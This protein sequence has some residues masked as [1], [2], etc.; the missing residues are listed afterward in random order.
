M[1]DKITVTCPKH[2]DFTQLAYDHLNGH[3]CPKCGLIESRNETEIYDYICSII[4]KE[5]VEQSNRK[6]LN[7]YEI[8]IYIPQIKVGIEYNGL[9]WHSVKYREDKNYH[10]N[11]TLKANEKGVKLIQIF[12]D[13]YLDKKEIVLSKIRR[14]IGLDYDLPKFYARKC[15]IKEIN[16]DIAKEF[17]NNNHI[18]GYVNSTVAFGCFDNENNK[19][20]GVMTFIKMKENE[21]ILNR[22][23]TDIHYKCIGVGGKLFKYFINHYNPNIVSSF[24]DLRWTVDRENNLYVK[25]GFKL[26][27]ICEPDYKY[28]DECHPTKRIHKF[29]CRKDILHKKYGFGLN[30]TE[31]QMTEKL[32]YHKIYDCGLL[33]Y[34][35][36][37]NIL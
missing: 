33:K 10:L 4:G 32:N 30:L 11:K 2:G 18:Q 14:L 1:H 26:N 22:F 15:H 8:D 20:I 7:G 34:V 37:K 3:G 9:K 6:I 28:V 36:D 24:A 13:E 19:L 35:Y 23:A 12:E 17:I 31:S 29:N 25:L 27:K 16:K 5:N 21:Y